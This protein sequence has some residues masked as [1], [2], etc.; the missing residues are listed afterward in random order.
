MDEKLESVINSIHDRNLKLWLIV[1]S[2]IIVLVSVSTALFYLDMFDMIPV[3]NPADADKIAMIFVFIIAIVIFFIKR[4]YLN[5]RKIIEMAKKRTSHGNREVLQILGDS[6]QNALLFSRTIDVLSRLSYSVWF[7]AD[8]IVIVAFVFFI[9]VPLLQNYLI[10][11]FVGLYSLFINK[12]D[13]RMLFKL[14]DY[15]YG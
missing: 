8:L 6:D 10:Y 4:S 13:R 3:V 14:Y 11:S 9:L 7:L 15:I 5:I 1:L 2:G 12:P